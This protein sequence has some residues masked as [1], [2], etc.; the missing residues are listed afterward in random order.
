MSDLSAKINAL[1]KEKGVTIL[2]HFYQ[3][4]DVQAVADHIGDSLGLSKIAKNNITTPYILFAGVLFM[5]ETASILN[6]T[7]TVLIPTKEAGCPMADQL[8]PEAVKEARKNNPDIPLIVYVNT[9]A[10]TK[11]FADCCCTSSNAVNICKQIAKEWK[12][13]K[14]L[15]GPDKNL[16]SYIAQ[17]TGLKLIIVPS[18]GCCPHHD[19]FTVSDVQQVAKYHPNAALLVHPESPAMV[20]KE[21]TEV[22]S[23]A[24]IEKY[25][26]AHPDQQDFIIGTENGMAEYLREKYPNQIFYELSNAAVCDDMKKITLE[27]MVAAMESIGTSAEKEFEVR[28]PASIASKAVISIDKMME[29][30]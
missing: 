4:M 29:L 14:I 1:K 9:T 16:G 28:V 3:T 2:A 22:G 15:F 6:Q 19:Q 20:L 25:V 21:A 23:T 24:G 27:N 12:T 30:S 5:A 7:K 26:K 11:A 17:Q 8:S 10:E 13:D 18:D